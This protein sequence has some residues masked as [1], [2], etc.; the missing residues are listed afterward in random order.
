M[1][2]ELIEYYLEKTFNSHEGLTKLGAT[3]DPKIA[4]VVDVLSENIEEVALLV[5]E[6]LSS[7]KV[8]ISPKKVAIKQIH[9]L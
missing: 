5:K 1:K 9:S 2:K 3:S 6:R 4:A 8:M 7:S